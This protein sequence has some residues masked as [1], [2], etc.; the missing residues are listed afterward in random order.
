MKAELSSVCLFQLVLDEP[1]R[2]YGPLCNAADHLICLTEDTPAHLQLQLS[3]NHSAGVFSMA[4]GYRAESP[5]TQKNPH[6]AAERRHDD[7]RQHQ[8]RSRTEHTG[9]M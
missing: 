3:A 9:N 8:R 7:V 5:Q 6:G 2:H 1:E 4:T